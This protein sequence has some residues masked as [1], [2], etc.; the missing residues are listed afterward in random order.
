MATLLEVDNLSV[1]FMARHGGTRRVLRAVEQVSL[2]VEEGESLG[3][4]G[5]SGSG[6]TTLGRAI[7][8]LWKP[9]AGAIR[10][11]GREVAGLTGR[12]LAD[13]RRHVQMVFQDPYDSLNPRMSVGTAIGEVLAIHGMR[14]RA[15]RVSRT[16]ELLRLVGLQDDFA[17][18]YPHEF[19]GGQRQRIG[20][21]R[22]LATGPSLI[23][24]DEPVSAL[25]VSVQVQIIA[26]MRRLQAEMGLSYV[27]IAHD[28][29]VVRT[30]CRRVV[31]MYLGRVV[32]SGL[33]GELF[34]KPAHPYTEALLSAVPDVDADL[35]PTLAQKRRIV[36]K[37]DVPSA[38]AVPAGCPFH[39]RCHRARPVCA[40]TLPAL[41]EVLPGR[42]S[43][44]HFAE[45]LLGSGPSSASTSV[46]SARP[47]S[48]EVGGSREKSI[49]R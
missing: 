20:I 19:S 16:A 2:A 44:C 8:G 9:A 27:F 11:R 38:T 49:L 10:F 47:Q 12:A 25:D 36:L 30:M 23:V 7:L 46:D 28:L 3:V 15:A 39:P 45:E 26:L 6:K 5:E 41:W 1:H 4:V 29:A 43:A 13:F 24:A 22:A 32:E 21:A 17:D 34:A 31:V 33:S 18:R 42:C 40:E 35:D 37:G 14:G 48:N